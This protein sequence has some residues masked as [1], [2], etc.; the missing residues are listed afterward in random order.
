ML[1]DELDDYEVVNRSGAV[2]LPK[3]PDVSLD[4]SAPAPATGACSLS[5]ACMVCTSIA[6]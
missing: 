4:G 1:E 6:V 3:A 5:A 2:V